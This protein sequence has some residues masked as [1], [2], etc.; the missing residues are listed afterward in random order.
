[1][2]S[3]KRKTQ[4]SHGASSIVAFEGQSL[5]SHPA[6]AGIVHP[7]RDGTLCRTP[8]CFGLSAVRSGFTSLEQ[9][10]SF[11]LPRA[12]TQKKGQK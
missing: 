4:E 10:G 11:P 12:D 2:L 9:G 1:M 3:S 6:R 5:I 8:R 7:P